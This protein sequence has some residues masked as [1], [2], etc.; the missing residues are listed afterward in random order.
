M[1]L[2]YLHN[3]Y[4]LSSYLQRQ[5]LK[6]SSK[7]KRT[8]RLMQNVLLSHTSIGE[9]PHTYKDPGPNAIKSTKPNIFLYAYATRA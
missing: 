1:A 8:V 3:N 2:I 6:H 5:T 4:R 7:I 9:L